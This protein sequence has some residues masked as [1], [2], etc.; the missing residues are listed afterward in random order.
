M[1]KWAV[2]FVTLLVFNIVVL[3]IIGLLTPARVGWAALWAGIIL[4]AL[5]IWV[6]PL[7]SRWFRSMAARS[8]G[9]LG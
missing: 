9:H 8:A 5:V 6:K 7:V 1:K 4:T 3:L 2:R